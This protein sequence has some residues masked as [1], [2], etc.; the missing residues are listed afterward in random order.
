MSQTRADNPAGITMQSTAQIMLTGPDGRGIPCTVLR[1]DD[2]A[3]EIRYAWQ[4]ETHVSVVTAGDL[5]ALDESGRYLGSPSV[6]G[7]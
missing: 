6:L 1:E 4:G 7:A 5:Y 3:Y 2:G